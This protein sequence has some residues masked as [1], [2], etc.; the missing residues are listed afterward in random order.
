LFFLKKV[1]KLNK[2]SKNN[3][4]KK[5]NKKGFTLIELLIVIAVIGILASVVLVGL[6]P[7]QKQGRD[8]RRISDLRQVQN[9][10]ELYYNKCGYYPGGVANPSCTGF[11]SIGDNWAALTSALTGSNIGISNVPKDPT[12]GKNY[13]YSSADGTKYCLGAELEDLN[14]PNW[15]NSTNCGITN[16]YDPSSSNPPTNGS[17]Y[18][19]GL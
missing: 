1:L 15:K 12:T 16:C 5:M 7:V 10:L 19:V 18:C 13:H 9:G 14:N 11:S 6:G 4:N 2:G 17:I 3:I 8:A